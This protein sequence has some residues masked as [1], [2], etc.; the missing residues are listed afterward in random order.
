MRRDKCPVT[1]SMTCSG[2]PASSRSVTTVCRRSWNR[3]PGS[4]AAFR[5]DRQAPSHLRAGFVPDARNR[6][7]TMI[8]IDQDHY[9][10]TSSMAAL[11]PLLRRP[12]SSLRI[13]SNSAIVHERRPA[14]RFSGFPSGSAVRHP[15][16]PPNHRAKRVLYWRLKFGRCAEPE[17]DEKLDQITVSDRGRFEGLSQSLSQFGFVGSA[18]SL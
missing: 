9:V 4:P 18:T 3:K 13:G 10:F 16:R 7:M 14:P 5:N 8:V 11:A 1:A 2:S 15:R 17:P 6:F 12:L